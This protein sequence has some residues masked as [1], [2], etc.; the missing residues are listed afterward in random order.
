MALTDEEQR[1]RLQ[2]KHF[3][4]YSLEYQ[5]FWQLV[6]GGGVL[7]TSN[8]R[9]NI[10]GSN[11][12]FLGDWEDVSIYGTIIISVLSDQAS[13]T[14]GFEVQWSE[15]GIRSIKTDTYTISA[16]ICK[17]VNLSPKY[18]YFR[19]QYTN[20]ATA[21]TSFQLQTVFKSVFNESILHGSEISSNN[22]T[23][24]NV[25]QFLSDGTEGV[26]ITDGTNFMPTM[27]DPTRKGYVQIL[28]KDNLP[29]EYDTKTTGITYGYPV[30]VNLEHHKVHEGDFYY[31]EENFNAVADSASEEILV[32]TNGTYQPHIK[33]NISGGGDCL[34]ELYEDVNVSDPGTSI[35][36]FNFDR[37][38]SKTPAL[39]IFDTP[40]YT[41]G[42][43]IATTRIFGG[44]KNQTRIGGNARTNTEFLLKLNTDYVIIVT[45]DSGGVIDIVAEGNWYEVEL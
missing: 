40:V 36:P 8:S 28:D 32:R 7:S 17:I 37:N 23:Q 41:S 16:D 24:L 19:I 33:F 21:Q 44:N 25:T 5:A 20:G 27:D 6:K 31:F 45:N 15:D 26:K 14:D 12:I 39:A 9:N 38:S 35:T 29:T 22:G 10:L 4:S 30:S 43:P 42:T 3:D 11:A 2:N 1:E 34:I 18:K 13:A